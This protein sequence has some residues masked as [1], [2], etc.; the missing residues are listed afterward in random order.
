MIFPIIFDI[1]NRNSESPLQ[2]VR[3]DYY[4]VL[5]NTQKGSLDITIWIDC[6]LNCLKNVSVLKYWYW[7]SALVVVSFHY[8]LNTLEKRFAL[9]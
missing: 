8:F 6:Y 5:E 9:N 3:N 1:G 2:Q 4:D 7:Y